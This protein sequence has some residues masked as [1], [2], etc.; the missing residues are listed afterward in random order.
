MDNNSTM[1]PMTKKTSTTDLIIII[2]Y[3]SE[4]QEHTLESGL[5]RINDNYV[6][7]VIRYLETG[8]FENKNHKNYIECY[9]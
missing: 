1:P 4:M 7:N 5:S 6:S 2:K 8:V 3:L 9:S